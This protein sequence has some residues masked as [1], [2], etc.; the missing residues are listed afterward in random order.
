MYE[1]GCRNVPG[2]DNQ[3]RVTPFYGEQPWMGSL[4]RSS[5]FLKWSMMIV[6]VY[7]TQLLSFINI[8]SCSSFIELVSMEIKHLSK[9]NVN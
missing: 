5:P 1:N 4:R 7:E 2:S 6:V 9:K 3:L 8:S